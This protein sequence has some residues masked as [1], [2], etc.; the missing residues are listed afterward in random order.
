MSDKEVSQIE[1]DA[2]EL[3]KRFARDIRGAEHWY[4]IQRAFTAGFTVQARN[5]ETSDQ[6]FYDR[7][8]MS[9]GTFH[10][11]LKI[12]KQLKTNK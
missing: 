6:R 1:K 11:I 7:W 9:R 4:N 12:A 10:A 2:Y 8:L 5:D 3:G